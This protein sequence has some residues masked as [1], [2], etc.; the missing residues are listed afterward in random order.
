MFVYVYLILDKEEVSRASENLIK[1]NDRIKH[2]ESELY[3]ES[4]REEFDVLD[5]I[6]DILYRQMLIFSG[7]SVSPYMPILGFVLGFPLVYLKFAQVKYC[8][9]KKHTIIP[10]TKQHRFFRF[11][12]VL[13]V[14]LSVAPFTMF[15]STESTCGP[16]GGYDCDVARADADYTSDL[17]SLSN[18]TC[19]ISDIV[20]IELNND[21]GFLSYVLEYASSA[22]V[23]WFV[24]IICGIALIADLRISASMSDDIKKY[25][26]KLKSEIE[27][28][29]HDYIRLDT[30][31]E[32]LHPAVKGKYGQALKT[33]NPSLSA[34]CKLDDKEIEAAIETVNKATGTSK[35]D[36]VLEQ[37]EILYQL[38]HYRHIL[39]VNETEEQIEDEDDIKTN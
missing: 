6:A 3:E 30:F 15:L 22:M 17:V 21:F 26:A 25:T 37:D 4:L 23:L 2:R 29:N 35:E 18:L 28:H 38:S 1:L 19:E 36:Y 11:S 5:N 24:L 20:V 27:S 8:S 32:A 10:V 16:Y 12:L 31:L 34:L 9:S 7:L 39:A 33:L 13:V 14:M